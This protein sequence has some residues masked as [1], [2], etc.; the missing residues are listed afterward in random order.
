MAETPA[1]CEHL[2]YP[3]QSGSDRVLAAD[4][5]RLHRR[6]L[7]RTAR[8]G[9]GDHRRP[10]GVDRHHRRASPARPTTTSSARSRSRPRPST[11]TPTR[12]SSRPRP[13]TEAADDGGR[14]R[15]SGS[16]Q[17]AFPA[18]APGGRAV[19]AAPSTRRGSGGSRR[20]SSRARASVTR[21]V[22]SGRTRQNKLVHFTPPRPLRTGSYATVRDHPRRTALPRRRLRRVPLRTDA[23]AAHPRRRALRRWSPLEPLDTRLAA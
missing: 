13:G 18:A 14:L 12:S 3:L 5:P 16:G 2:H 8:P 17:R 19:G 15:R 1:V 7:P 23:Q 10:R 9:A 21:S 11:T 22:I 20:C 6:A 4:A